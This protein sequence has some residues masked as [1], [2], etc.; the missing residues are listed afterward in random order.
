MHNLPIILLGLVIMISACGGKKNNPDYQ[1]TYSHVRG[2]DLMLTEAGSALYSDLKGHANLTVSSDG[3]T[4]MLYASGLTPNTRYAAH[5]HESQ[6]SSGG[7]GHYLQNLSGEDVAENGL[8]PV[9]ETDLQGV[10]MTEDMKAFMVREDA[11]SVVIHQLGSGDRI[12]CADLTSSTAKMG[13]F[14]PINSGVSMSMYDTLTG[15][16]YVSVRSDNSSKAEVSVMGLMNNEDYPAHVHVGDCESLGGDHYLQDPAKEDVAEN[17]L[18]PLTMVDEFGHGS[19]W[20]V[21]P[22]MVRFDE[23]QSIILHDPQSNERIACADLVDN[24]LAFRS[25]SFNATETGISLYGDDAIEGRALLSISPMGSSIVELY[26]S[27]L[28]SDTSYASHVHNGT[29]ASGG[30][31]HYLQ[32]MDGEDTAQNGLWPA[33]MTDTDGVGLTEVVA[34]FV[35]RNDARSVVVHQPVTGDRIAC[36]D[37]L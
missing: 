15:S 11:K 10:A 32:M 37:L 17:G 4:V 9:L 36:A 12:A 3:S 19:G 2:G 31:G 14:M 23:A 21:N 24:K 34:D 20:A 25:G 8:W 1:A 33:F 28:N 29:C 30:G 6:C 26:I 13:M 35:V 27:G 7:G 22:F 16:G 5:V 18:W